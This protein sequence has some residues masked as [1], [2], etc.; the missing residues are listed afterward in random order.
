MHERWQLLFVYW[1]TGG[2]MISLL[3]EERYEKKRVN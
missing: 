2:A 3:S 1:I